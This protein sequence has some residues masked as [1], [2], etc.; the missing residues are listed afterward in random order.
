[1]SSTLTTTVTQLPESRVRVQVQVPPAEVSDRVERKARQLGRDLRLPGFRRGKVPAPLVLQRVG[2]EA[3]LEEA[4]RDSL[5]GWYV[6]ALAASGIDP[7]GDPDVDL[8]ELPPQGEALEFSFEIAVLPKATLGEYKGLEVPR[9]EPTVAEESLEGEL[10]ALRERL[11]R[12]ETADR[13]AGK[14]DFVVL[15]YVGSLLPPEP[16]AASAQD[17]PET[18]TPFP[19]GEGRDQLV[20]LGAADLIPGFEQGLLGASAGERRT[21][22]VSF[23]DPYP[24]NDEL[25]G[26]RASFEVTV[27]EV[28]RKELPEIDEDLAI[29]AGFDSVGELRADL[30]ARLEDVERE[31]V[32][33]EF[34]EAALDAAVAEAEV[35][36]PEA[37]V[38]ARAAEM[39]ERMLHELSHQGISREAYMRIAGLQNEQ[40][41]LTEI[42]PEAERG[43][44]REAV[45]AAI[46]AA[47]QIEPDEEDLRGGI[48][49]LAERE[50]L[51][52]S[53]LLTRLSEAGRL[54]ALREEVAARKA[55]DLVAEQAKPI[56]VE[57]AQARE[58][59][60]TPE[61]RRGAEGPPARERRGAPSGER[62]GSRL[63]TPGDPGSTS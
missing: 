8:G 30:R 49:P 18:A 42:A 35:Q 48:G 44:R 16:A 43:L 34:R 63:W 9:R 23:P 37:L 19:G 53:A 31:R 22:E 13:P 33:R 60:W 17:P 26:R 40:Q 54:E 41:I 39:W 27:K 11:A 51:D 15:D 4:V 46:V 12:L 10:E 6:D 5:S 56:P 36:V 47:E 1:M 59:L 21:V 38:Q 52:P 20:E 61:Q 28:K 25:A 14:G 32:R 2:R 58:R 7:V 55:V 50:G 29:D 57:Q 24:A 3:V 45:V 62:R